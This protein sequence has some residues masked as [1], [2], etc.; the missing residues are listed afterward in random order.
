MRPPLASAS[1]SVQTYNS[2][3]DAFVYVVYYMSQ[4]QCSQYG[5]G[6]TTYVAITYSTE[7]DTS[8]MRSRRLV[9]LLVPMQCH[10][11]VRVHD[12]RYNVF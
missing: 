11:V 10:C 4:T 7:D 2:D 5:T 9:E 8:T 3:M 6:N 1:A 12:Q